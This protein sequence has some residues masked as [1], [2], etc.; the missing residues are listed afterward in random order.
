MCVARRSEKIVEYEASAGHRQLSVY[1]IVRT[2]S[3]KF[4]PEIDVMLRKSNLIS[5][6][7][8]PLVTWNRVST[9]SFNSP[10][11]SDPIGQNWLDHL[12]EHQC[13]TVV[14]GLKP[15]S[16]PFR[17]ASHPLLLRILGRLVHSC[18]S[19]C[20]NG[21]IERHDLRRLC[22]RDTDSEA[23]PLKCTMWDRVQTLVVHF[24][25]E[26]AHFWN[27][28]YTRFQVYCRSTQAVVAI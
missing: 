22:R 3:S 9:V 8:Q 14:H 20:T 23:D 17:D 6:R 10:P 15:H 18:F 2:T 28:L 11:P 5:L 21:H 7:A 24:I 12:N 13:S 26:S 25:S 27:Y 1:S 4:A 16:S 19:N